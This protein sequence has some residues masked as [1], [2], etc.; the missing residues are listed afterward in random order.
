MNKN[1]SLILALTLLTQMGCSGNFG[2]MNLNDMITSAGQIG[3]A[4]SGFSSTE[5]Y[6]IGRTTSA[7]ILGRYAPLKGKEN[8]YI[9]K[10]GALLAAYSDMRE[11][12]GGYHFQILK[13][14]EVNALSTPGGFIFITEGMLKLTENEDELAAVLAH[15]VAHINLAHGTKALRQEGFTSV[16]TK[17]GAAAMKEYGNQWVSTATSILEDRTSL[18][19]DTL[20]TK[21]YSRSQEYD[22]DEY[23]VQ[24]LTRAGYNPQA[25]VR[26]LEKMKAQET[27]ES[28]GIFST[29]PSTEDRLA[30]VKDLIHTKNASIGSNE[31]VRTARYKRSIYTGSTS[32]NLKK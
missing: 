4:F 8:D 13:G 24:L 18:L 28:G 6:Q 30:E 17:V 11:T 9:Q 3:R 1:I 25:F 21:G 23:A 16:A 22:A 7:K 27:K 5:E 29:H 14:N 31:E 20:I 19:L 32:K 26:V 15:E 2:G 12:Y 10:V